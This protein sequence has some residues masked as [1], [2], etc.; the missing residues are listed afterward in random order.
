MPNF[1]RGDQATIRSR[2]FNVDELETAVQEHFSETATATDS[3]NEE[4]T[5]LNDFKKVIDD[6]KR[7]IKT[8][9][10]E[11]KDKLDCITL[12]TIDEIKKLYDYCNVIFP[13]R[14]FDIIYQ[15]AD[16]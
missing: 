6:L 16:I 2:C 15:N 14:F 3:H 1:A 8:S 4:D 11:L 13:E 7:D 9:F 5:L 12:N 10:P